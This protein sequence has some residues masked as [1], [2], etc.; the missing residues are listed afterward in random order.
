M[1]NELIMIL[2]LLVFLFFLLKKSAINYQW[3]NVDAKLLI[4]LHFGYYSK[5]TFSRVEV[6]LTCYRSHVCFY[7]VFRLLLFYFV[8]EWGFLS[9][10]IVAF[11][12]KVGREVRKKGTA[13]A[14]KK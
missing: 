9:G 4:R 3:A 11:V 6:H 12:S 10:L 7:P 5:A 1:G 2:R 8:C 14:R 13:R